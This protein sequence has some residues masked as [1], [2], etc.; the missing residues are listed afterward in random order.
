MSLSE[1]RSSV[2]VVR[3]GSYVRIVVFLVEGNEIV[4]V[5]TNISVHLVC[6]KKPRD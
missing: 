4:D 1:E 6:T 5:L 2:V 3:P